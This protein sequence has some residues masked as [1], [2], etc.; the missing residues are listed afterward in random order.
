[1]LIFRNLVLLETVIRMRKGVSFQ[2]EF[3]QPDECAKLKS[4]EQLEWWSDGRGSK[5]LQAQGLVGILLGA[6]RSRHRPAVPSATP[7]HDLLFASV[8]ERKVSDRDDCKVRFK[9]NRVRLTLKLLDPASID[10]VTAFVA[11][12]AAQRRYNNKYAAVVHESVLLQVYGHFWQS[13]KHEHT[14]P[15]TRTRAC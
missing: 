6:Q 1:M 11:S 13:E 14:N 3:D 2:V 15:R 7:Y 4:K 10:K 12:E 5:M 8:C 9:G